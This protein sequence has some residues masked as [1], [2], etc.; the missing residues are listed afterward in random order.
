MPLLFLFASF[1]PSYSSTM[2]QLSTSS[3]RTWGRPIL[4]APILA[5]KSE[6]EAKR[7]HKGRSHIQ[8]PTTFILPSS[9]S[10]PGQELLRPCATLPQSVVLQLDK[11]LCQGWVLLMRI[12]FMKT[13][14]GKLTIPQP[15]FCY[16]VGFL[17]VVKTLWLCFCS[18][19][20]R[21]CVDNHR[22]KHKQ[23]TLLLWGW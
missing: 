13:K 1:S 16:F 17:I 21:G 3:T 20:E 12:W 11:S 15:R 2:L 9:C 14:N 10:S 4:Q 18:K 6:S 8:S 22:P 5:L 23:I 19:R 7:G